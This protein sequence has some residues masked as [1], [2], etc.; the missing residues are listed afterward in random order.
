MKNMICAFCGKKKGIFE[1]FTKYD[2]CKS[3]NG[4]VRDSITRALEKLEQE[5]PACSPEHLDEKTT[6]Q[7]LEQVEELLLV[8]QKLEALRPRVPFFKASTVEYARALVSYQTQYKTGLTPEGQKL[9]GAA[10]ERERGRRKLG[11]YFSAM[12]DDVRTV[13]V[14]IA[15]NATKRQ[16]SAGVEDLIYSR[17]AKG[18]DV[19]KMGA[20]VT[21]N[22]ETTNS[23]VRRGAIVRVSAMK[24]I[25]FLPTEFFTTLVLP[26]NELTVKEEEFSGVTNEMLRGAPT[27]SEIVPSLWRFMNGFHIV[28][29]RLEFDL[30]FL[31]AYGF[32]V[33]REGRRFFDTFQIAQTVLEKTPSG[34]DKQLARR[35]GCELDY[36]IE[37]YEL[38]TMYEY[39]GIIRDDETRMSSDCLAVG[40]LFKMLVVTRNEPTLRRRAP[41]LP[42]EAQSAK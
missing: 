27:M 38:Q 29:Y 32:P 25:N 5:V 9:T 35:L 19:R 24:F 10:D 39:Y 30:R 3:C 13:P 11:E 42:Q 17:V 31:S 18:E 6:E 14:E 4:K 23:N 7:L 26:E 2:F 22:V 36:D 33:T 28:G 20:F 21:L 41:Q 34:W 15:E 12:L 37:D 40:L 16:P 1:S 8:I